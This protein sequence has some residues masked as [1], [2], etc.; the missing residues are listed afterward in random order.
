MRLNIHVIASCFTLL[1]VGSAHAD[2]IPP[3]VGACQNKQVGDA[4]TNNGTGVCQAQTCTRLDY[5][6]WNRD[7]S[8]G[9]PSM[10]YAC[11]KCV[12]T[13]STGTSTQTSTTPTATATS[14]PTSTATVTN[15]VTPTATATVSNTATP[16]QT[17]TT[18]PTATTTN[19]VTTQPTETSTTT[20][21]VTP[22]ETT[23]NTAKPSETST[24]TN[25]N[26]FT[27]PPSV[28]ST[29]TGTKPNDEPPS[30][31][32]GSCSVGKQISAKRIAPWLLAGAF[33]LL[34]LFGRRRRR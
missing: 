3:E 1:L 31:D 2:V 17:A 12:A 16:T 30:N 33:S 25:T 29:A 7:A 15:T 26:G 28:T 34:F 5:A 19:T 22:P 32:D 18:A 10:S 20:V 4:C 24:T 14:T 23:T 6:N 11:N 8:S 13:T 27:A 9:P 21:T